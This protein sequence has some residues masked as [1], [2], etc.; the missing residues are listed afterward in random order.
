MI[1]KN[2]SIIEV[3]R[4][5][6]QSRE[7]FIKHGMSCVGCMGAVME[8]IENGAR[9]HGINVEVLVKELNDTILKK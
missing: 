7:V 6:P 3:L 5:I 8:T 4:S 9:L 1:T 2:T